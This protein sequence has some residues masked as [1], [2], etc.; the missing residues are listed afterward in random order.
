MSNNYHVEQLADGEHSFQE[1]RN[2]LDATQAEAEAVLEM[3]FEL[4]YIIDT[5][6]G[7]RRT[8]IPTPELENLAKEPGRASKLQDNIH[9]ILNQDIQ[10]EDEQGYAAIPTFE[11][12]EYIVKE[13]IHSVQVQRKQKIKGSKHTW[14]DTDYQIWKCEWDEK[15]R[16]FFMFTRPDTNFEVQVGT[17]RNT[18]Q[19]LEPDMFEEYREPMA[20]GPADEIEEI[21]SVPDNADDRGWEAVKNS[22]VAWVDVR[23]PMNPL[24]ESDKQAVVE[25]IDIDQAIDMYLTH[26]H[27]ID[28]TLK[29]TFRGLM[30]DFNDGGMDHE[31]VMPYNPHTIAI[32]NTGVGKSTTAEHIGLVVERASDA[33]LLGFSSADE[34]SR[35]E[36][37]ERTRLVAFDEIEK[38]DNKFLEKLSSFLANGQVRTYKGKAGIVT[39]GSCNIAAFANPYTQE[40]LQDSE[41]SGDLTDYNNNIKMQ[42]LL[43]SFD[44]VLHKISEASGFSALG[45]RL[46]IVNFGNSYDTAQKSSEKDYTEAKIEKNH[47]IVQSMMNQTRSKVRRIF[48]SEEVREWLDQDLDQYEQEVQENLEEKDNLMPAVRDFWKG[49]MVANKRIRGFALKQAI[50]DNIKELWLDDDFTPY[51]HADR[52]IEDA[53]K[54]LAKTMR[55]NLESLQNMG[56]VEGTEDNIIH[57]RWKSLDDYKANI[58]LALAE[59]VRSE[60][61]ETT[62]KEGVL[63]SS[64]VSRYYDELDDSKK[65]GRMDKFYKVESRIPDSTGKLSNQLHQSFGVKVSERGEYQYRVETD[66]VLTLASKE[67][68]SEEDTS[69][70]NMRDK[71]FQYIQANQPVGSVE[72]EKEY[73][74]KGVQHL[75]KLESDGRIYQSEPDKYEVL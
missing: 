2:I 42:R 7:P 8:I 28:D 10:E 48:E 45:R 9:Y 47:Q 33:G 41:D 49:N 36:L 26:N 27:E 5:E 75:T 31:K 56:E 37:N 67:L 55:I 52:I 61:V 38:S 68:N 65:R 39:K 62:I 57:H 12:N 72:V 3:L 17:Q 24:K 51:K 53:E 15:G 22:P 18:L 66:D 25:N 40:E 63:D 19:Y 11:R 44:E 6:K 4:G 35:G 70:T 60:G 71:V 14:Y 13:L 58:V 59:Y 64:K 54:H 23:R 1:T 32:T 74:D 69:S 20:L 46:A 73:G 34:I 50:L 43:E 30:V 16:E 21:F 29:Y